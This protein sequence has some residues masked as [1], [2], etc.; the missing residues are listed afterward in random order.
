MARSLEHGDHPLCLSVSYFGTLPEVHEADQ[1]QAAAREAAAEGLAAAEGVVAAEGS[2]GETRRSDAAGGGRHASD[3]GVAAHHLHASSA[4]VEGVA[5]SAGGA[6]PVWPAGPSCSGEAAA[7]RIYRET[8]KAAMAAR[9]ADE[10]ATRSSV[11]RTGPRGARRTSTPRS[12]RLGA[13]PEGVAPD[14]V[15]GQVLASGSFPADVSLGPKPPPISPGGL[16]AGLL[17]GRIGD[18]GLQ[19]V[20]PKQPAFPPRSAAAKLAAVVHRSLPVPPPVPGPDS[21]SFRPRLVLPPPHMVLPQPP[22]PPPPPIAGGSETGKG[23]GPQTG[24]S[25]EPHLDDFAW[26]FKRGDPPARFRQD[27]P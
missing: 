3:D 13:A 5:V 8:H 7:L 15:V 27:G 23:Y 20:G 16:V 25:Q 4:A 26:A 17:R 10:E 19:T 22:L 1:D 2:R 12:S 11:W 18:L 14:D 9:S 6:E 21:S 24:R